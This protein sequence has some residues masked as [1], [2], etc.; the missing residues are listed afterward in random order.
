MIGKFN[1]LVKEALRTIMRNKGV[2]ALSVMIMSL[3]LLMLAV[4]LLATDNLL[5]VIADAQRDMKVY[6]YLEEPLASGKIEALHQDIFAMEEAQQVLFVPKEQALVDF[7][8]QLGEEA[9][10]LEAIETNPLPNAFWVIPRQEHKNKT[11]MAYLAGKVQQLEGVAEVRYGKEFVDKFSAIVRGV[12]FVD[13][14]V[15]LIVILSA[16][17]IIANAVR[18]TVISRR[19]TIE[20]LKLVGAT[21]RF[22]TMPFVLE[23][24]VQGGLAALLSLGMLVGIFL[25]SQK[26][27]PDLTYF[28][29]EKSS[30][31]TLACITIGS[32]GSFVSL[33]RHLRV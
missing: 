24:A 7:R 29:W 16:I 4:F 10:L 1:Y 31:Y 23:G 3:S 30:L 13:I 20:I 27:I 2:T 12:Y 18:L 15:G 8:E 28:S 32:L 11:S 14:A 9:D 22:I 33:R 6:V 21:N 25:I 26:F 17:F 19:K 5:R